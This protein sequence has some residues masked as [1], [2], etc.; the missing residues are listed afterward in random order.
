MNTLRAIGST[1]IV[2]LR[3]VV[4]P[5]CA[6]IL[7]KLEYDVPGHT[8]VA[9]QRARTNEARVIAIGTTVVRALEGGAADGAGRLEART[10]WTDIRIGAGFRPRIVD[11]LFTGLHQHGQTHYELL[12]AF[13]PDEALR[14][15][16]DYADDDGYL[17]HEFGDAMVVI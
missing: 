17:T 3:E 5:G 13:A 11:A 7:V 8:A 2:R 4:P 10:G 1:S 14:A 9:V 12:R 6:D 15:A 16:L